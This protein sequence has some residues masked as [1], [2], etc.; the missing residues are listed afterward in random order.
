MQNDDVLDRPEA[1]VVS[2][3]SRLRQARDDAG[4]TRKR[5]EELTGISAKTIEKYERDDTEPSISRVAAM[6]KA[7]G[8]PFEEIMAEL[9]LSADEG[10]APAGYGVR[11]GIDPGNVPDQGS[12]PQ[13][14]ANSLRRLP[15][16]VIIGNAKASEL[17]VGGAELLAIRSAV[18]M[19][20]INSRA[21]PARID[22]AQSVMSELGETELA[23]L[24]DFV[25]VTLV[26]C[27]D[28]DKDLLDMLASLGAHDRDRL[29]ENI[30]ARLIVETIYQHRFAALDASE[31]NALILTMDKDGLGV[32]MFDTRKVESKGVFESW[33][34]F[35]DRALRELP[36]ALIEAIKGRKPVPIREASDISQDTKDDA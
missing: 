30:Q 18:A 14:S 2:V 7:Y 6:C 13:N 22:A 8:L 25:G 32:G 16:G 20:G 28:D 11:P 27:V 24:A 35:H 23:S 33:D 34:K 21:L 9:G 4:L 31:M 29:C 12:E 19:D 5:A 17:P 26:G 1:A 3:G 15:P 36:P 10:D